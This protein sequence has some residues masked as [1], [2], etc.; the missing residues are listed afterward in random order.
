[1]SAANALRGISG[2]FEVGRLLLAAGGASAI[3]FPVLF[4]AWDVMVMGR[5]FDVTAFCLAYP[6]G[7]S[8]LVAG[9]VISIGSKDKSVAVAR[10]TIAMP[11]LDDKGSSA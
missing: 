2:E 10:Q 3:V 9:G 6:G 5:A 4:V 8:A 11:P 7:L 1:M